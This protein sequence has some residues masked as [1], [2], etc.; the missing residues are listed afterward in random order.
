MPPAAPAGPPSLDT[1]LASL[2]RQP[3]PGD[4]VE[5]RQRLYLVDEVVPSAGEMTRVL[6]SCLDDDAR[7][8]RL[9]ILWELEL[10]ARVVRPES[11][12]LGAVRSVDPPRHFAAYLHAVKWNCITAT[13]ARLFQAPFRAGIQLHDHQLTPLKKALELP[14]VNLFI[15]DD[16]GVGKT[17]EAGLVMQE[18]LLRQRVDW[19]LVVCPASVALQWRDEMARRFGLHFELYHR[20][21]VARRR[22]ERGFAVNPWSTHHRFIISY[23]AL[24]RPEYREPLLRHLSERAPGSLLVLDEAHTAAPASATRYAVDSQVTKVIRD[25][26]PRFENRLFL[27]ATPHNGHSNSFSSLL[28]ILDPQRF[29]R[30]VPARPEA[31]APVLVRRLKQDLRAAGVDGYPERKVIEIQLEHRDGHWSERWLEEDAPPRAPSPLGEGPAPELELTSLLEAYAAAMRPE[32]GRGRLVFVSLQKRLLSS[33]EAFHRTLCVHRDHLG[34][35][36]APAAAPEPEEDERGPTEEQEEASA[37]EEIA[38]ATAGV[39]PAPQGARALLD[40]MVDLAGRFR[41]APDAKVR[42]LVAWILRELCPAGRWNDRRVI[43]FTEYADTKR[44]LLQQLGAAL[45]EHTDVEDRIAQLHGGMGDEARDEV[46]RAFNGPPAEFPVRILV[47]TDA[48][49]E[50]INL[51]GHCADLFHFDVP[52]NPARME[53]R[54]GR[55]DRALQPERLVRCAYFT[56]PQ[57]REDRVLQTVVRKVKRIQQEVGS[58][59]GVVMERFD[60]ALADGID[61]SAEQRLAEAEELGSRRQTAEEELERARAAR[62][63]LEAELREVGQI[64]NDS[65]EVIAYEPALLEDAVDVGLELLGARK[66]TPAPIQDGERRYEAFR[67]PELP[68]SW[69]RTLDGLRPPR[70]PDEAPWDWRGRPLMPVV[71]APPDRMNQALAHLHLQHPVVQR[72]FSRFLSQG[73]SSQDLSRVTVVRS[74]RDGLARVIAYARLSVFGPGAVRLHD[75]LLSVAAQWRQDRPLQPF[76][77]KADR[78]AIEQLE[79]TLA[80]SPSL[81]G[82]SPAVQGRL[83]AAARGDFAALWK[84]LEAEADEKENQVRRRLANR[85]EEEARALERIL[86]DQRAAIRKELQGRQLEIPFEEMSRDELDQW[87]HDKRHMEARLAHIDQEIAT[88]PALLARRY[89]V[90]LVRVTPVGLVYLWPASGAAA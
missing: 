87:R 29:T 30:G 10:G 43:V 6:L 40:R 14:R 56:Y 35:R 59:A 78:R 26:A 9:E 84:Y 5:A 49:R 24:R 23:Q 3:R 70:R 31:H 2:T 47:A 16:V 83:L 80:E 4:L 61:A 1:L 54:N 36:G 64:R 68:A 72:L 8:R 11:E 7:G 22:Q 58:L 21:F 46:Q 45:E 86:T 25:V 62:E 17:I 12:G 71:F 67:L 52:W 89:S 63:R 75:E 33:V 50:G 69:E 37:A 74:S 65:R 57:R 38:F 53:Q 60:R 39:G 32:R 66:L 48:A 90:S 88:E 42:S 81:D 15:A 34:R 76:A 44:Y 82:L 41:N 20:A 13:D 28:E 77:D 73:F 18:L 19:V 79:A 27:S 51:Q 85:G 55:I